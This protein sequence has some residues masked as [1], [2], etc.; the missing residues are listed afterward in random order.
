ME[1]RVQSKTCG[2]RPEAEEWVQPPNRW[3]AKN[4]DNLKLVK[5]MLLG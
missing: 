3:L 5:P 2:E 4:Y 1:D